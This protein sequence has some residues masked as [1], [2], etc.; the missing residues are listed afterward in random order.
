MN[1]LMKNSELKAIVN[2]KL[3]DKSAVLG[4][5]KKKGLYIK[6]ITENIYG[7]LGFSPY[8]SSYTK[9]I[10]S[11]TVIGVRIESVEVLLHRLC[12]D[13][14][15]KF[16]S[17]TLGMNIGYLMPQRKYYEWDFSNEK[18][19][20]S[21]IE[22]WSN[23]LQEYGYNY[24][25]E[26]GNFDKVFDIFN[27]DKN[28]TNSQKETYIPVLYYLMGEKEKGLKYIEET[29]KKY[30]HI[31]RDKFLKVINMKTKEI[32]KYDIDTLSDKDILALLKPGYEI[33]SPYTPKLEPYYMTFVENYRAL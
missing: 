22:S 26:M 24:Y 11:N 6:P 10:L 31:T 2:K 17:Y 16:L 15:E 23:A 14:R 9:Q 1:N 8:I 20:D 25:K 29:I 19:I 4:F 30:N 7:T 5:V 32:I 18:Q 13:E 33:Q 27:N 12:F 21:Q 3:A 28:I